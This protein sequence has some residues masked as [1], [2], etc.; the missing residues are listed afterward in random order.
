MSTT[1]VDVPAKASSITVKLLVTEYAILKLRPPLSDGDMKFC[2]E[3]LSLNS[4]TTSSKYKGAE[5]PNVF[6][7]STPQEISVL[8]PAKELPAG[9]PTAWAMDQGWK[10][11]QVLGPMP[12]NLV[13]VLSL[14]SS[15]LC[16]A[17]VSL[18]AQSTFDTDYVFVKEGKVDAAVA[19][20]VA[21]GVNVS[22][23]A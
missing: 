14:L 7:A 23:V 10:C 21:R 17:G 11:F 20:F 4:N 15:T 13:G 19:A 2:I 3:L 1:S 18:L 6:L 9:S 5:K 8:C 16:E 22:V 12:F